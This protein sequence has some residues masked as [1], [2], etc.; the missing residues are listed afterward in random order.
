MVSEPLSAL[1]PLQP[2]DAV[3]AVAFVADHVSVELL[4]LATE[5]GAALIKTVGAGELTET[6]ADCV[7]LP[8]GPVH[9][10]EY[11]ELADTAPVDCEPLSLLE[12]LQPPDALQE[13]ALVL[14][15]VSEEVAPDFTL[16]G[17]AVIVTIGATR[18]TV[19]VADCLADPPAP[20]Q[21]SSYSVVFVRA[22]VDQVPLVATLPCQPPEAVQAVASA[23]VQVRVE[24]LPLP[25]VVGAAV[26]VTDAAVGGITDTST[27]VG[28]AT[29][30]VPA[31]STVCEREDSPHAASVLS[32]ANPS[33]VFNANADTERRLP[34]I[35]PITRLPG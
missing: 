21:V 31:T 24:L 7:A 10:K 30:V 2:P 3:Q 14:D 35:E 19:T 5:L 15:Q 13:V 12:P 33:I 18:D 28:G 25:T 16:L 23:D 8:P 17:V 26:N 9:V 11:V 27:D 32:A 20:V 1:L 22:P 34:R 4:P 6:V 29:A